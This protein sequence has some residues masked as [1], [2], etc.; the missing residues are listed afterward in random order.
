MPKL[1]DWKGNLNLTRPII[2]LETIWKL[3]NKILTNRLTFTIQQY[4]LISLL[5]WAELSGGKI[6]YLI[7]TLSNIIEQSREMKQSL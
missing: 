1:R 2:L 3:Y 7:I 6:T 5:N 4:Q